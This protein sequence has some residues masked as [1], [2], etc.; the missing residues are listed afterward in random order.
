MALVEIPPVFLRK[1]LDVAPPCR[2]WLHEMTQLLGLHICSTRELD[3][4]RREFVITRQYRL[5]LL[6]S[7][8]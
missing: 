2:E 8:A 1:F 3:V 7:G 5:F 4:I 6:S